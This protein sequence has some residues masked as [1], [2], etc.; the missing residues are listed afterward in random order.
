MATVSWMSMA[1]I[2]VTPT[3]TKYVAAINMCARRPHF[4]ALPKCYAGRPRRSRLWRVRDSRPGGD[5]Q[6]QHAGTRVVQDE[7]KLRQAR[8]LLGLALAVS[9]LA[10]GCSRFAIPPR[11]ASEYC[12]SRRM[13]VDTDKGVTTYSQ[14]DP[15]TLVEV[16]SIKASDRAPFVDWLDEHGKDPIEYAVETAAK[17][18]ITIFGEY[19]WRRDILDFF[20]S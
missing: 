17:H 3:L 4:L 1:Q 9:V 7:I 16:S 20:N 11:L 18:E 8:V 5:E 2:L 15:S 6:Q 12:A 14:R 13:A 10:P 19:H